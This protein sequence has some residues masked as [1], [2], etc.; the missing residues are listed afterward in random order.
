MPYIDTHCTYEEVYSPA[1]VYIF[2]GPCA[3]TG[4]PYTVR[5]PAQAL[6]AYRR[7]AYIQDAMY[8]LSA[9][10]RE[11]VLSGVSPEGWR[12]MFGGDGE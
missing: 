10:D 11:F 3:V 7:G 12:Q 1:H 4:N 8:M 9:G 2:T 6:F 5:I